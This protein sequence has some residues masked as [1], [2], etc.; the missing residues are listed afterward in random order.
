MLTRYILDGIIINELPEGWE[1]RVTT[2]NND[3]DLKGR[4][5]TEDATLTWYADGYVYIKSIFD[6]DIVGEIAIEIQNDALHNGT[7]VTSYEGILKMP[8]CQ[9]NIAPN[10]VKTKI[11]DDGFY[12]R[13]NN[14]KSIKTTVNNG[15]SKNDVEIDVAA[16]LLLNC[17][18]PVDGT[19][20]YSQRTCYSID[21]CFRYMIDFVSDGEVGYVS[22]TF[23]V[24]LTTPGEY[25]KF[26][27][28]RG[29]ELRLGNTN[30]DV[31][32]ELDFKTLYKEV[33]KKFNIGFRMERINGKP[34]MRIEKESWFYQNSPSV[35]FNNLRDIN[36][37]VDADFLY[38]AIELGSSTT[39]LVGDFPE[40]V[41]WLGFYDEQFYLLGKS[42][43]DRVLDLKSDWIISSNVIGDVVVNNADS[44]DDDIFIIEINNFTG[45]LA[46]ATNWLSSTPPYYYNENLINQ[47]VTDRWLDGIPSSIVAQ[48]GIADYRFRAIDTNSYSVYIVP[49]AAG[50]ND[51]SSH[52]Q[53]SDDYTQPYQF[54]PSNSY[55]DGTAQG[56][57]V[58]QA[59]SRYTA[60]AGGIFSFV[61]H[62]TYIVYDNGIGMAVLPYVEF[63]RY[64][65]LNVIVETVRNYGDHDNNITYHLYV[66]HSF[67][68][69]SG[70]YIIVR[71]GFQTISLGPVGAQRGAIT[72]SLQGSWFMCT[73]TSLDKG[74]E[75]TTTQIINQRYM[76]YS[77]K[78]VPVTEEQVA[79]IIE[80][81]AQPVWMNV[82]GNNN[83]KGWI[84]KIKFNRSE[85]TADI[86]IRGR[87]IDEPI[88]P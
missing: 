10:Y 23:F 56:T 5:V 73:F 59:K 3:R 9:F 66:A 29:I 15:R 19:F 43:I 31:F 1:K 87:R 69:N 13:I 80:D 25:A 12:S 41:R 60:I 61:A 45:V 27:I 8:G 36:R 20:G 21:E 54:D 57:P 86:E 26:V 48:L 79:I 85:G 64:N 35:Q 55:G 33:D 38:S 53:F 88:N 51:Y 62:W 7:W 30:T 22:D 81:T 16:P 46:S 65:S 4:L 28:I 75:Y 6:N 67:A 52:R 74:G 77:A 70:D 44:Y 63:V 58:T 18:D 82:D 68:L 83:Y 11:E 76:N 32:L 72:Q 34:T 17:F 50:V 84:D 39:E 37:T 2:I 71:T 40:D 42:N 78:D 14:N 49:Y 47:H 24:D